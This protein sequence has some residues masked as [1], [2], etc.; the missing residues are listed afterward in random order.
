LPTARWLRPRPGPP[1]HLAPQTSNFHTTLAYFTYSWKSLART[2]THARLL[3]DVLL[4]LAAWFLLSDSI[5]TV[6][7]TAVLFAKTTLGMSYA[8]LALINVIATLI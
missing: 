7:G 5:A 6:S 2:A 4:F 1:L 8:M 3:K